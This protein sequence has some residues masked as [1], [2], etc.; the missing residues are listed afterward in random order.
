MSDIK[1]VIKLLC[2]ILHAITKMNVKA[3][4]F[5]LGKFNIKDANCVSN[6]LYKNNEIRLIFLLPLF[7]LD[8]GK[9]TIV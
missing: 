6:K 3:E 2:H 1:S 8:F 5:R 7:N 9:R 4:Y